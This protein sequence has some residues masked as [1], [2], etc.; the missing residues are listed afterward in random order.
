MTH[1]HVLT[2]TF[3][4]VCTVKGCVVLP[5][6]D[7][8]TVPKETCKMSNETYN[9]SKYK[10]SNE[11]YKMSNETY[12]KSKATHNISNE[13]YTSKETHTSKVEAQAKQDAGARAT[14]FGS[15]STSPMLGMGGGMDPNH[16]F[17][18]SQF[19]ARHDEAACEAAVGTCEIAHESQRE[20]HVHF[21]VAE[22]AGPV[23]RYSNARET[24]SGMLGLCGL[25]R[26]PARR[27]TD[28]T[29]HV[30]FKEEEAEEGSRTK[31]CKANIYIC[32]YVYMYIYLYVCIIK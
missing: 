13:T 14:T 27:G 29:R 30:H 12:N 5:A 18:T 4:Q 32:I 17:D 16:R 26:S 11:T 23:S 8:E 21:E 7:V 3:I 31:V 25:T 15:C 2:H 24:G 9:M 28:D 1:S 19:Y 6:A 22:E 20:R 10:M